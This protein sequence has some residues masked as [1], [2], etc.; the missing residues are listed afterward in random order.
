MVLFSLSLISAQQFFNNPCPERPV[1]QNFDLQKVSSKAGESNKIII[2]MKS[3]DII[4]HL[5]ERHN[6]FK[7][8][9]FCVNKGK[10]LFVFMLLGLFLFSSHLTFF[11][12]TRDFQKK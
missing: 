11:F 3:A 5:P 2:P 1:Q 12:S 7:R 6:S 8:L 9:S 4:I 10:E